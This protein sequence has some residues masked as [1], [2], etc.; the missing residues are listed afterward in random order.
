M[1]RGVQQWMALLV[2]C[3]FIPGCLLNSVQSITR[4][5]RT[6]PDAAH[7]LLLPRNFTLEPA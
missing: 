1:K 5:P 4:A 7:P 3:P 2:V 6:K